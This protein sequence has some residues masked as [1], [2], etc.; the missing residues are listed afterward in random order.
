MHD[1]LPPTAEIAQPKLI[2]GEWCGVTYQA[3][4]DFVSNRGDLEFYTVD[5][6][7][8]CG[9]I[10]KQAK[11]ATPGASAGFPSISAH[12]RADVLANWQ[13]KRGDPCEAFSFFEAHKRTLMN[14]ISIDE[15]LAQNQKLR[16][17]PAIGFYGIR[18]TGF[19]CASA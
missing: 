18:T 1:C 6:D 4:I 11:P 2:P 12:T 7:Y 17:T 16:R 9:I 3:F 8:G 14:S 10:H 15:F 5:T 13:T 19:R